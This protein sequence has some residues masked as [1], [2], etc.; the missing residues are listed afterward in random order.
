[1]RS[2]F[3]NRQ[4]TAVD[5]AGVAPDA[6]FA[7]PE[8]AYAPHAFWFW[9]GP[10]ELKTP[11]HFSRMAAEMARQG[12]NPGYLHARYYTPDRAFWLTP[13]WYDSVKAA[14]DGAAAAGAH[15]SYTMGDPSF[16]DKYILPAHPELKAVSLAWTRQDVTGGGIAAIPPAFF[17]VAARLDAAGRIRSSTLELLAA[18]GAFTWC[19]PPGATWR[20]FAFTQYHGVHPGGTAINVLDR[21]VTALW[22]ELEHAHYE[23]L[24]GGYFGNT[25]DGIFFDH[26]GSYGYKLAWS[27]DLAMDYLKRQGLDIRLRMPLMIEEDAEGLW[28]KAR[29]DWFDTV[30]RLY[31]D[32]LLIPL[33]KW[34]RER[35]MS[36]T[37][38]LWEESLMAQALQTGSF[39]GGQRSYSMPGTDA[40]FLEILKPRPFKETQSVCELEGRPCMC[41][42]LGIAGWHL[43]PAMMKAAANAAVARGVTR[44]VPHGVNSSRELRNVSY[45]PDFFNWNP[46]WRHFHLWTDFVRRASHVNDHGRL[47][48]Q[49]LLFCPMD[50]V[51]ALLGDG[52]FDPAKPHDSYLIEGKHFDDAKHAP[53][54]RA[55]DEAY[56]KAMEALD[57][58]R[59]EHLLA[60]SHYL[61]RMTVAGA[62]LTHGG[63]AFTTLILPPLKLLPLAV[64][65]RLAE[66]AQ[67]GGRVIA[68]GTLPDASAEHGAGDP[69]MQQQMA[70]LRNAS[71][72]VEAPNGLAPLLA[73]KAPGLTPSV[74]FEQGEFPL[75]A[76]ARVINGRRFLWLANNEAIRHACVLRINQA[77][78]EAARWNCETGSRQTIPSENLPHGGSRVALILEPYEAYWLVFDPARPPLVLPPS[79]SPGGGETKT[80]AGPWTVGV[81]ARDQ[82][83]PAQ[84]RLAAPNWLLLGDAQRPLESWLNWE[85]RQFSGFV[86]YHQHF[87]L[88]VVSGDEILDLGEVRHLAEVWVNG[89]SAGARLWAPFRFEIGKLLTRGG[90][91]LQVKVGNLVLNAVTQYDGYNWK[92]Y[93]P[94]ANDMLDAGLFGPVTVVT[95]LSQA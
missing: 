83:D 94:P 2:R 32:C 80:L 39:F 22:L 15:V 63:F 35:G 93:K 1:M 71:R 89:V 27:E 33:D 16:P 48:A 18:G 21:R 54:I 47:D 70:T 51:W 37:C 4:G 41:E 81:D 14:A 55:I 7:C 76:S 45:P 78:G 57:G 11:V 49:V 59:V 91:S 40:L 74:V 87:E 5:G 24:I 95:P 58:A 72:F 20:V 3:S 26:E 61:R 43:T 30:T 19:A 62:T 46:Y 73:A 67:A 66:F 25:M 50:S 13:E 82:P 90:N 12:L 38:H 6:A 52:I 23:T 53:E 65:S 42:T 77:A 75:L 28:P 10:E 9:N 69:A 92:W 8:M 34:C 44:L 88:D 29:W 85:L 17:T 64:A 84:H 31:D 86:D 68:L 56:T 60:D 36:L 79:A